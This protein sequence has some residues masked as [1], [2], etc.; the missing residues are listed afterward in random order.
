MRIK[1]AYHPLRTLA[2]AVLALAGCAS[3]QEMEV[4]SAGTFE[5]YA[6]PAGSRTVNDGLSTRWVEGDEFNLY[7]AVSGGQSYVSDGAF[8]VEDCETGLSRGTVKSLSEAEYDWF[9]AYPFS[10]S[11]TQPGMIPVTVGAASGAAQVQQGADSRA[12][13][14]GRTFPLWGRAAAVPAGDAPVLSVSPALSVIAVQVTNPGEADANITD[15]RFE[16][17]EEIVGTFRLD[18]TGEAPA[19]TAVSASREA[20]LSVAGGALLE[21]GQ[22]AVFYLGIK[23]FVAGAGTTLKLTVND[24]ER[25]TTVMRPVVFA[26]G[27]MKTLNVTLDTTEPETRTPRHFKRVTA[28]TPGKKYLLVSEDDKTSSLRMAGAMPEGTANGKMP[29]DDVR[30]TDGII[31]LYDTEN[32]FSFFEAENGILI[33]QPDGRYI[34]NN[35]TNDDVYVGTAPGAGYYWT[36]TFDESGRAVLVNRSYQFKY[37]STSSVRKFQIRKTSGAGIPPFLY[38]LQNDDETVT[39]FLENSQVGVYEF[40]GETWLYREGVHQ[41]SRRTSASTVEFRLFQPADYVVVQVSGL[42]ETL[43]ENDRFSV[44]MNRYDR[45][46]LTHSGH[47]T[48]TVLKMEDGKAWLFADG[49]TGFIVSTQ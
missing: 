23:P 37:N 38:E 36:V 29:A 19:F 25:V 41:L 34:Y 45:Q 27:K 31:T 18:V 47:F 13:L 8:A 35:R 6:Q 33:R 16:A 43:A 15:I 44:R 11:A 21:K 26:A 14:A 12:H 20:V 39:R 24:Q 28:V 42:P 17:P 4:P 3:V 40:G 5:V 1:P 2:A 7:H 48:V 49:G 10:A 46:A 9:M 30:E 32:A 22:S